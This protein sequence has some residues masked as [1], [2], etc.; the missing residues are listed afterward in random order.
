MQLDY[1]RLIVD[2]F[3]F[4]YISKFLLVHDFYIYLFLFF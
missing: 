2:L 4:N 3:L 1:Y